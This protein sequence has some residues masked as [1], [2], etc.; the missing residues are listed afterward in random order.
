[1]SQTVLPVQLSFSIQAHSNFLKSSRFWR[2]AWRNQARF[3]GVKM[4]V[5]FCCTIFGGRGEMIVT[6]C[7]TQWQIQTRRLG[8]SEIGGAP[9]RSSRVE[10]TKAVCHNR[11]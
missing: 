6:C 3:S 9:K 11:W 2:A 8:D 10:I 5:T 4:I 7:C 1:M